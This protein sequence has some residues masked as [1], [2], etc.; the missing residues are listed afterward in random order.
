MPAHVKRIQARLERLDITRSPEELP[1][2]WECHPLRGDL[3]G[4][5]S[6]KISG[7][8]RLIFRFEDGLFCDL[9]YVQYH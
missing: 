6:I 2:E 8:W 7:A 4:F 3:D 9:D 1:P 5:Y